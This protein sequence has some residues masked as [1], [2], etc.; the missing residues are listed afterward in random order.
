MPLLL[1]KRTSG[2]SAYAIWNI[3]ETNEQ[4]FELIDEPY[5][6][7]L[8]PTRQA[9]WIVGRIL[10]KSLC[11][12]F[13]LEYKGIAPNEHGKPYLNGLNAEISISHSFP[14]A[15]A[16]IHLHKPCGIDLERARQKLINTQDKFINDSE[17]QYHDQLEKLCAIWC[18]KEVLY[19]IYGRRKL[20]MKDHTTIEFLSDDKMNG[21]IHK[22]AKHENYQIHFE[23][24]KDYFLAH[25]L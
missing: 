10:V 16:M 23:P 25:S 14:M 7:D 3:Q 4:L 15:A 8:N 17:I 19:K 1:S 2:Y 24:V 13:D 20:S 9:E 18:G 11:L 6:T 5:P 22:E 21:I 12:Q